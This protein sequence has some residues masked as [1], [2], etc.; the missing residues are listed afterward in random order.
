MVSG[1]VSQ[2]II[3]RKKNRSTV[4][5][6]KNTVECAISF[7]A[8]GLDTTVTTTDYRLVAQVGT[9]FDQLR[10]VN[11]EQIKWTSAEANWI[12]QG[13]CRRPKKDCFEKRRESEPMNV[14]NGKWCSGCG[15]AGATRHQYLLQ[16][17][18]CH[19]LQF[20]S[21]PLILF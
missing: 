7:L 8:N 12:G 15:H 3:L 4:Y 5:S 21:F 18:C 13:F 1:T 6:I 20:S 2:K 11:K 17:L 10:R 16:S 19:S 14:P 9:T